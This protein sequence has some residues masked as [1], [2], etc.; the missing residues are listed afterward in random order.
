MR[1]HETRKL[2]DLASK[3]C[4]NGEIP[5]FMTVELILASREIFGGQT[6]KPRLIRSPD[7][8]YGRTVHTKGMVC[9]SFASSLTTGVI[10]AG[11]G[12]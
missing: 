9:T 3:S 4:A 11:A 1:D 12:G 7:S 5:R 2:N 10:A 8:L 6:H